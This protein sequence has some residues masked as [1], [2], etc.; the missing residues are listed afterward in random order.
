[1]F[2]TSVIKT[3]IEHIER[4]FASGK[5]VREFSRTLSYGGYVL[6]PNSFW[7]PDH[8]GRYETLLIEVDVKNKTIFIA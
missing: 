1:M 8:V 7:H 5:E 2:K 4:Y 6:A 3:D